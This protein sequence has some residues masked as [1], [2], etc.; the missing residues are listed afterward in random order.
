MGMR[1]RGAVRQILAMAGQVVSVRQDTVAVDKTRKPIFLGSGTQVKI[2]EYPLTIDPQGEIHVNICN[3][4]NNKISI[5]VSD[6][7]RDIYVSN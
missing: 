4:N 7:M 1:E 3:E 6:Y 5:R 2:S